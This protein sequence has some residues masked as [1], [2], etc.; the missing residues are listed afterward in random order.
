MEEQDGSSD[1]L[2]TSAPHFHPLQQEQAAHFQLLQHFSCFYQ[3]QHDDGQD[4]D[5]QQPAVDKLANN[6]P[7]E[8]VTV[9][10][11]D[12][13]EQMGMYVYTCTATHGMSARD[14]TFLSCC[15]QVGCWH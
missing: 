11:V 1:H 7:L 14:I 12:Y 8:R 3:G 2:K 10:C 9:N 6:K 4:I 13:N 5:G 15:T